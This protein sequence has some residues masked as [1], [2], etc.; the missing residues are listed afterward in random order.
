MIIPNPTTSQY[1]SYV[2]ADYQQ[3]T[4]VITITG[5]RLLWLKCIYLVK[6][7]LDQ[8]CYELAGGCY[9]E[10]AFEYL[11]G[12]FIHLINSRNLSH[13]TFFRI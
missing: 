6:S 4:S 13:P 5:T 8:N 11:P 9:A 1:N 2:G 10:Y 7:I 3:A 12:Q